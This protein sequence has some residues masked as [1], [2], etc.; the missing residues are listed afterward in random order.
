MYVHGALQSIGDPYRHWIRL[1]IY[2]MLNLGLFINDWWWTPILSSTILSGILIKLIKHSTND[3]TLF[4]HSDKKSIKKKPTK[5]NPIDLKSTWRLMILSKRHSY[6]FV[7][8]RN[9]TVD[10][11]PP[12]VLVTL[13]DN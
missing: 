13:G 6:F 3:P 11:T 7:V 2:Q 1:R 10:L 4:Y 5:M 12:A 8:V 9:W